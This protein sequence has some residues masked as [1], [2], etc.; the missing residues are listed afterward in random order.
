MWMRIEITKNLI[1][2]RKR[3]L[4]CLEHKMRNGDG[5]FNTHITNEGQGTVQNN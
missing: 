1:T 5:K 3:Q 4:K 2:I